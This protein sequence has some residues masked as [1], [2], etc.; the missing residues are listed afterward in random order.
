M[1]MEEL[2]RRSQSELNVIRTFR[3]DG[4]SVFTGAN[5]PLLTIG[6]FVRYELLHER[7]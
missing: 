7:R 6:G 5:G 4:R 2:K 3:E 1:I